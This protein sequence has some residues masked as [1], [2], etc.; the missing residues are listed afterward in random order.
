MTTEKKVLIVDDEV[1]ILNSLKRHF[2]KKFNIA[3]ASSGPEALTMLAEQDD[4]AVIISDMNMPVMT[5]DEFL[6]KAKEIRPNTLRVMLTGKADTKTPIEAINKGDI[7]RFHNKPCQAET[8]EH[9]INDALQQYQLVMAEKELL[10][11]TLTGSI[12][13]LSELLSMINPEAFGHTS[14]IKLYVTDIG[15]ELGIENIWELDIMASLSLI[16]CILLPEAATKKLSL[17]QALNEEEQQLFNMHP[18]VGAELISK[19]PRMQH[20]AE[21]IKYQE[22]L[23]NG[24][25]IPHDNVK[26]NAIPIGARIL[27]VVIDYDRLLAS[28]KSEQHTIDIL[29]S[30]HTHYDPNVLNAFLK[31]L[32]A[33]LLLEEQIIPIIALKEGMFLTQDLYTKANRLVLC[34]GQETTT[35]ICNKLTTLLKNGAIKETIAVHI[36]NEEDET[37]D[38]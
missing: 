12:Q 24:E 14:L 28:G 18:T 36:K 6:A 4:Y 27:K 35:S 31:C 22:K 33:E 26:G 2:H 29:K 15:N 17:G 13:I 32:H 1:N 16:G 21:S 30:Q 38:N 5:G 19:I 25:G 34:K 7:F 8:L 11:K 23:F 37:P 9:T 10:E 3:T 20:I